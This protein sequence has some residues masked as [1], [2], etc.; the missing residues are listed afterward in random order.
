M[1]ISYMLAMSIQISPGIYNS[2]KNTYKTYNE[3][4]YEKRNLKWISMDPKDAPNSEDII[5]SED[6]TKW[7]W[8]ENTGIGVKME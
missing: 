5:V 3:C 8:D 6:C 1:I 2:V 4:Q 7:W